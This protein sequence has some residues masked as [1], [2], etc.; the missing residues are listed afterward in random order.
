MG[1]ELSP[2]VARDCDALGMYVG[3][4]WSNLDKILDHESV[5]DQEFFAILQHYYDMVIGISKDE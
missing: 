3:I 1:R 2:D 5:S 4:L